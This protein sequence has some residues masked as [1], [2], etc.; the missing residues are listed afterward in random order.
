[1]YNGA[2]LSSG[3]YL[4]RAYLPVSFV[5]ESHTSKTVICT[6][7]ISTDKARMNAR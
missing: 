1:M 4:V 2:S 7:Y 6:Y 3:N 5:Y